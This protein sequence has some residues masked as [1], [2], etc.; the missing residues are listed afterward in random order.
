MDSDKITADQLLD[1]DAVQRFQDLNTQLIAVLTTM[2]DL[3]KNAIQLDQALK[4]QSQTAGQLSTTTDQVNTSKKKLTDAEKEA[5]KIETLQQQ[6]LDANS[7]S[8]KQLTAQNKLL[9]IERNNLSTSTKEGQKAIA[10]LNKQMDENTSTIKENSTEYEKQKMN[11]GNYKSALDAMPGPFEAFVNGIKNMTKAALAFMATPL[12]LVLAAVALAIKSVMSYFKDTEEGENK[13]SE[14][15][16]ALKAV[17]HGVEEVFAKVGKAIVT[18]ITEPKKALEWF[19]QAGDDISKWWSD[20]IGKSWLGGWHMFTTGLA[21][22]VA[23]V[24]LLWQKFKDNFSDNAKKVADAQQTLTDKI[25]E[26]KKAQ[27]EYATGVENMHTSIKNG[28]DSIIE[29][30]EEFIAE[31]K[32]KAALGA[33]YAKLE[34]SIHKQ[35]RD[36]EIENSNLR[37]QS[38]ALM[39]QATELKK[40]DAN[41]A[42]GLQEKAMALDQKVLQN[43]LNIAQQKVKAQ[44]LKGEFS[45]KDIEYYDELAR[46]E[47]D[48]N[49]K[50]AAFDEQKRNRMR[51]LTQ[52]RMEAFT[53]EKDR[54][55]TTLDTNKN[56]TESEIA[57]NKTIIDNETSTYEQRL[58]AANENAIAQNKIIEDQ[59]ALQVAEVKKK[60]ELKLLSESDGAAQILKI[61]SDK[62]KQIYALD[63]S[64]DKDIKAIQ[65]KRISDMDKETQDK[66]EHINE[67]Y[68][69]GKISAGQLA[70]ETLKI[71][72]KMAEDELNLANLTADQKISLQEK[73]TNLKIKQLDKEKK[74]QEDVYKAGVDLINNF[75]ALQSTL[76]DAE[77]S[78][79]ETQRTQK[80]AIAKDDKAQQ[81]KINADYDKKEAEVKRKQAISDRN[82]AL[83]NAAINIAQGETKALA[84]AGFAGIAM[85]GLI[86]AAGMLQ[87]AAIMNKPLPT[88]AKGVRGFSG[89]DAIV[90]EAG[91]EAIKLPSGKVFLSPDKATKMALPKGADVFTHNETKQMLEGGA[92]VEKWD[93]MIKEQKATRKALSG[94]VE[95]HLEIT[96][97]GW[98]STQV[99]LNSRIEYINKYFRV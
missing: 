60:V 50:E 78:K 2:G 19:K 12:G 72:I 96:P 16:N 1:K 45:A 84:T 70:D 88:F 40:T 99:T 87:I 17:W 64:Y 36:D 62:N 39:E 15:T 92:T 51:R 47:A 91:Y 86:A 85:A 61:E 4:S 59:T 94:K 97:E 22:G 18:A 43:D 67:E 77:V 54:L 69:A 89:G 75:F 82:Q 95:N 52:L 6:I 38:A 28:I 53:Q 68:L 31:E 98:K 3:S 44:K 20:T 58:E 79:L 71:Q 34:A 66:I 63:L 25:N 10:D 41:T 65:A 48:V 26:N 7:G 37:R 42:I 29:K 32:R 83:F 30:T 5:M 90:G 13:L 76:Y 35:E 14:A 74:V 73:V 9:T 55:Q 27:L 23:E 81:A 24:N 21:V 93:E 46:L 8:V 80:L 57:Q 11:I 56:L 49:N 33:E